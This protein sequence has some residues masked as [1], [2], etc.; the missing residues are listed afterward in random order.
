MHRDV[1]PVGLDL[2]TSFDFCT[3][4]RWPDFP[5]SW[6]VGDSWLQ[7]L[8][9][10]GIAVMLSKKAR[11]GTVCMAC[12]ACGCVA[13]VACAACR[14]VQEGLDAWAPRWAEALHVFCMAFVTFPAQIHTS[15]R[16]GR[17][18]CKGSWW[19]SPC[20][21]AGDHRQTWDYLRRLLWWQHWHEI[22][23]KICII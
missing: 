16:E 11:T 8:H 19:Q 23:A 12:A 2:L 10:E 20:P 15:L 4:F 21:A 6:S 18:S 5:L 13:C 17:W 7:W 3:E 22:Q 9:A 1:A 14:T